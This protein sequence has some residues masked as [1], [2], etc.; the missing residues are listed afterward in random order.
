MD[1]LSELVHK[2]EKSLNQDVVLKRRIEHIQSSIKEGRAV[3][4]VNIKE[5]G[6]FT[7]SLE[8]KKFHLKPRKASKPLLS[9]KVPLPLFKE[10]LLGNERIAYALLDKGCM[11]SF[12][13]PH[14]THWDGITALSVI[15][16]AQ[17]MVKKDPGIKKVV[18][19]L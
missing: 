3:V 19:E 9:W 16:T 10:V 11:L 17:E 7:I 15:L 18:E 2:W 5:R 13:T 14:F 12:D 6:V 8:E 1:S 4:E